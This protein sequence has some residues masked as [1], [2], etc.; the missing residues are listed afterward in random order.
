MN[1]ALYDDIADWYDSYLRENALYSESIL[2]MLLA[3]TGDVQGQRICD[4]ACGQGWVAR[5][6]ARRGATVT[7][8]DLSERLLAIARRYEEQEPSGITYLQ[9]DVQHG[10]VLAKSSFDGCVC[11]WS[12]ADIPDL[13]AVFRTL[14]QFLKAGGWL[15][16]AIPHPCFET[17]HA[18][19]VEVD[20]HRVARLV[21]GYF[22]EG[23]WQSEQGGV[24]SRVGAYHRMLSTYLNTLAATGFVLEEMREPMAVGERARQ[25]KGNQEVPSLL[26]LRAHKR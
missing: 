3:L 6:L 1:R 26:G 12:L 2:P 9:A 15:V 10:D 24:R 4:L 25:V 13:A 21:S 16:V 17:P 22:N 7:G 23:F 14:W 5:E 19:W 11:I 8:I 18:R 20:D